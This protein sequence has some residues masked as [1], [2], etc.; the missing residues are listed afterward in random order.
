MGFS[1]YFLIVADFIQFAK[2][3]N[4]P[5]GPGRGSGAG[6]LVAWALTITDIDP[7]RF[8]LLFERFLNP[9]RKSMPDFDIDFCQERR[10]EVIEYVCER[11]GRERVAH[12]ITF[13]KLQARA[14]LRDVGRVLQMPYSQVDRICKLIPQNPTSPV[15]IEHALALEPILTKMIQE[16]E[17]VSKLINMGRKLEGL[18]RHASTHAAGV[19]IGDRPLD[20]TVPLY[21]DPSS[22]LPATQFN[23]KYV[24]T[25][26]LVK[27]DFLGLKTL[28]VIEACCKLIRRKDPHFYIRNI[29]LN[30]PLTFQLLCRVEAVGVFQ[31]ES[32]GMKDVLKKLKPDCFEDLIA[33]VALY[34][35][36][37]MDDIPRYLACKHGE[38]KVS[39]AHPDLQPI[40]EKTYGVMVY[41]EQ[42][43]KIAQVL[44]GYTLGAA[45][46]LRRAMGKKIKSEMD[47]QRAI[48]LEGALKKG[49]ES[50][51]AHSIFDQMA[52]F[53]GYGFNKSHASPYAL[54]AYQTAFLKAN[55]TKEFFAAIMTYDMHNIDKLVSYK[56]DL[57]R[58]N[59]K[60]LPPDMNTSESIFS[61]Q[62][63]H[64]RYGL[65]AI[66]NVG[67]QAM[68]EVIEERER[69][70]IFKS[71]A[72]FGDRIDRRH[73]N[74]RQMENLVYAGAFDTI[75]PN[76]HQ[77]F[78]SIDR[79]LSTPGSSRDTQQQT[80]FGATLQH[81][82]WSPVDV[83]D[84]STDE[85]L[86]KE[87]EALGFYLSSHPLAEYA[88]TLKA[89]HV[90]PCHNIS[91][92]T[93]ATTIRLAGVILAKQD[94]T[95][96]SGQKYCF[97]TLSDPSGTC[98]LALFSEIYE[99]SRD[100][101]I[102]G[103]VVL[104]S[105]AVRKDGDSVR[106][107]AQS[108]DMLEGYLLEEDLHL[109]IQPNFDINGLKNIL[110]SLNVGRSAIILHYTPTTIQGEVILT[111]PTRYAITIAMK[112]NIE[113][114]TGVS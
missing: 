64:V 66:K 81:D 80:L 86:Q 2:S 42:V 77:V 46:I 55:Y 52:K 6:S 103:K 87:F 110:Q 28:T 36:G 26:G 70:G 10:D 1:G 109:H 69:K 72:D 4:I 98:E 76:R 73:I 71:L 49:I 21:K 84:W 51:I 89:Y 41:Q 13:G 31:L 65:A 16:E 29:P 35:P 47:A 111:L 61:V 48:F 114:L 30:D 62:N 45:D 17:A 108:L 14:V 18:Y 60:L 43:M 39:Y 99:A 22:P 85:Y 5:V 9:E 58:Y 34:R 53:A 23:M 100:K 93:S 11:Y 97:L 78:E 63:N 24:E 113:A 74:K 40:L 56:Q 20:E 54:L 38:E 37:P 112:K 67:H 27:F 92:L 68:N 50:S 102:P 75:C 33:L 94:R 104:V 3:Q 95:S 83:K 59:I 12:I 91:T 79:I 25:A 19:V 15:T 88:E 106:L 32:G 44:G 7:I 105:A 101:I 82:A 107:T 8:D 57:E 90:T 96:K